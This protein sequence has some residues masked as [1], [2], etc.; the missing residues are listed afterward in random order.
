MRRRRYTIEPDRV[1]GVRGRS[2]PRSPLLLN[3]TIASVQLEK[4][5]SPP[6]LR[7]IWTIACCAFRMQLVCCFQAAE[8]MGQIHCLRPPCHQQLESRQDMTARTSSS[9][10]RFCSGRFLFR[11]PFLAAFRFI[12]DWLFFACRFFLGSCFLFVPSLTARPRHRRA[13]M[14]CPTEG[15]VMKRLGQ[16]KCRNC[17][18][19]FRPDPR[20]YRSGPLCRHASK[21]ASQRQ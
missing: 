6:R 7:D 17:G 11:V 3:E 19:W 1:I 13:R 9:S 21:G 20:R 16:R 5:R 4:I 2:A 15:R 10:G 12:K 14:I 8:K 18:A